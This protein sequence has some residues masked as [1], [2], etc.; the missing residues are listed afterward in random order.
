MAVM[1]AA[2]S[3]TDV[4]LVRSGKNLLDQVSWS[5]QDSER[6]VVLG[7][8]GAGKS[9]L[10]SLASARQHPTRGT[11]EILDETLGR[12]DVFELRPRIG[13][14]SSHLADQIPGGETVADVVLTAAYGVAGRWREHYDEA[15]TERAAQLLSDWN[16]QGLADRKFGSLSSGERARTS[17]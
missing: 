4:D 2:L 7:P 10:L 11:V 8:N 3:M 12:V 15:D 1:S 13:L 14:T 6:W 9:T 16:L 5:V 17:R